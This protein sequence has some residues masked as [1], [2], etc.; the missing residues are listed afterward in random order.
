MPK[1]NALRVFS[2]AAIVFSAWFYTLTLK[3][4]R[5]AAI[6]PRALLILLAACA[7]GLLIRSCLGEHAN[8]SLGIKNR[9]R[10]LMGAVLFVLYVAGIYAVGYYLASLAFI[11]VLSGFLAYRKFLFMAVAALG[12]P[13]SIYVVF[14]IFLKIPM[15]E[16]IWF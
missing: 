5:G 1:L 4:P 11:V 9:G 8:E 6:L 16:G 3:F 10:V 15:P 13:L 12:Y 7:A 14:Q 2:L